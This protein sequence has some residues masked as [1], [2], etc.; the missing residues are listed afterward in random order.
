MLAAITRKPVDRHPVAPIYLDLYLAEE[1]RRC[2]L[3]GYKRYLGDRQ[4]IALE[5][6]AEEEIQAQAIIEAWRTLVPAPDWLFWM[7]LL[8]TTKWLAQCVLCREEERLWRIHLPSGQ[9]EE[10]SQLVNPSDVI[11]GRWEHSWPTSREE[12]DALTPVLTRRRALSQRSAQR[13]APSRG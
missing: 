10:L 7:P 2:A 11:V 13:N 5:P 1:V 9:R 3:D 4:E 12:I 6:E 8:P